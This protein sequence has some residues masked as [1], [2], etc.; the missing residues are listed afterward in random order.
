MAMRRNSP[1]KVIQRAI[2]QALAI[3]RWFVFP[4]NENPYRSYA[5]ISDLIAIKKGRVVFIEVKTEAKTSKQ[6][7]AQIEF[8][9]RIK[10]QGGEYLLARRTEDI[11]PLL[12]CLKR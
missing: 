8:E 6:R 12:D 5:G 2:I 1:E 7:P 3:D 11:D 4:I 9:R 10:E